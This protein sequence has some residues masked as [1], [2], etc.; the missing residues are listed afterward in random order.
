MVK[1]GGT[2]FG[3]SGAWN[4]FPSQFHN[5][6]YNRRHILWL[7]LLLALDVVVRW[8][9]HVYVGSP[10]KGTP[11]GCVCGGLGLPLLWGLHREC[12]AYFLD[13]GLFIPAAHYLAFG[14]GAR[15]PQV[16]SSVRS[17]SPL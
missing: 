5:R 2:D 11:L 4:L 1:C 15:L 12:R 14:F 8:F 7:H 13:H 16:T 9:R 3:H 6:S 10:P 17:R